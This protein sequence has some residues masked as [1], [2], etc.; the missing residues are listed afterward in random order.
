MRYLQLAWKS[1]RKGATGDKSSPVP[2]KNREWTG[3]TTCKSV[4]PA[5]NQKNQQKGSRR[6]WRQKPNGKCQLRSSYSTT[7]IPASRLHKTESSLKSSAVTLPVWKRRLA[8]SC[9]HC[10]R[11]LNHLSNSAVSTLMVDVR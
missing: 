4:E 3:K 2:E 8:A 7:V 9:N 6:S 1:V 10:G 11:S 5:D